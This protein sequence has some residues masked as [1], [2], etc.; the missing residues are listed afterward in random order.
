MDDGTMTEREA[1]LLIAV[2]LEAIGM[3]WSGDGMPLTGLCSIVRYLNLDGL[4]SDAVRNRMNRR[5]RRALRKH[6]YSRA[7]AYLE[8]PYRAAPRIK[9]CLKFAEE[10]K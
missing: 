10:C 6:Q 9:W 5:I 3:P 2:H 8:R 7:L 4:I 1:W